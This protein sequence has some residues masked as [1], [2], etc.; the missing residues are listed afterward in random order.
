M[1]QIRLVDA[2]LRSPAS[3]PSH[4]R[5]VMIIAEKWAE[6]RVLMRAYA[7]SRDQ[8]MP[9]ILLHGVELAIGPAGV[10][11]NGPWGIHVGDGPEGI[12]ARAAT[13]RH[14]LEESARRLAGSKGN[15]PRLVDEEATFD[16]EPTGNWTPGSPPVLPHG[17]HGPLG[18]PPP[19][20]DYVAPVGASR[21]PQH[22]MAT[23]IPQVTAAQQ[24]PSTSVH[25]HRHV[26]APSNP[27]LR[28]TPVPRPR[29]KTR[30]PGPH[31]NART[32]LGYS[33]GAGA[34]SAV[35]RLGLA[36]HVSSQ[37]GRLVER[38]VPAEFHIDS[39]ERRVLNALGEVDEATARS[40][41]QLVG[42]ADAVHFME[43]LTRKLE[44]FGLGDL[45]EP[46]SPNGGEPT[47]RMRR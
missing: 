11:V 23:F 16:R 27:E 1:A 32:A 22:Q 18:S 7:Q 20:V 38:I 35:V 36:P 37:L 8:T 19:R 29:S 41:G 45:V 4:Y 14:G 28:L 42:V 26:V 12:E 31:E 25:H 6:Q 10:D 33:S 3:A 17:P 39:R 34:Q 13:V 5:S 40:I 30:P 2:W 15:P 9:T 46:G 44:Q 43:E 24:M 47:Y 21:V